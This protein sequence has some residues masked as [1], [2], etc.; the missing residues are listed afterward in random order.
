MA[1]LGSVSTKVSKGFVPYDTF[2]RLMKPLNFTSASD[3]YAWCKNGQRPRNIPA[4][5]HRI[6]RGEWEGYPVGLGYGARWKRDCSRAPLL[7]GSIAHRNY[8]NYLNTAKALR[9]AQKWLS[10]CCQE[11]EFIPLP[12]LARAS[13]LFRKCIPSGERPVD[14]WGALL[15]KSTTKRHTSGNR[16][17][18]SFTCSA[19]CVSNDVGLLIAFPDDDRLDLRSFADVDIKTG[20]P[21][22]RCVWFSTSD[23]PRLVGPQDENATGAA[24]AHT[25]DFKRHVAD[26][27]K[28]NP[29]LSF[30]DWCEKLIS[31]RSMHKLT[32]TRLNELAQLLYAPAAVSW[33]FHRAACGVLHTTVVNGLRCVHRSGYMKPVSGHVVV[34]LD[35][36]WV[37]SDADN[38]LSPESPFDAPDPFDCCVVMVFKKK[39]AVTDYGQLAT[40]QGAFFLPKAF[41][42]EQRL[43]CDGPISGRR[44]LFT[45]YPPDRTNSASRRRRSM[46]EAAQE[47]YVDL[48]HVSYDAT[49]SSN[50]GTPSNDVSPPNHIVRFHAILQRIKDEAFTC[51]DRNRSFKDGEG[52]QPCKELR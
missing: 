34:N 51:K 49:T 44:F 23:I 52:A 1:S 21:G 25:E 9:W 38:G 33:E 10:S 20:S 13:F 41:L 32:V 29:R 12:R 14:A 39:S 7:E 46:V 19:A 26:L 48:R 2:K 27:W 4:T 43:I 22:S 11:Y 8:K 16:F 28:A 30:A 15:L 45:L 31:A 42:V 5:P 36:S 37:R 40:L 47:F 24:R 50:A 18:Y 35:F 17:H 6:Y 3:F